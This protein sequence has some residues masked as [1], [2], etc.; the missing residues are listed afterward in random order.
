MK[1]IEKLKE[2]TLGLKF[3]VYIVYLWVICIIKLM[4]WKIKAKKLI[5]TTREI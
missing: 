3:I 1:K 2:K 4:L 5:M